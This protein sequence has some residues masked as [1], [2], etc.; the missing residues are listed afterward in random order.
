M[1]FRKAIIEAARRAGAPKH[2]LKKMSTR[3]PLD[4]AILDKQMEFKPG[5]TSEQLISEFHSIFSN[6]ALLDSFIYWLWTELDAMNK[7]N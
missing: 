4:P 2:V 7:R 6:P 3:R 1:T 5:H